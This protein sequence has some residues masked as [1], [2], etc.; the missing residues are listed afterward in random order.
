MLTYHHEMY[1]VI[2]ID[3]CMSNSKLIVKYVQHA[4]RFIK[5]QLNEND[6]HNIVRTEIIFN[7]LHLNTILN[8]RDPIYLLKCQHGHVITSIIRCGINT[9]S[10]P[11]FKNAAV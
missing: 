1:C 4:H 8:N 2:F 7:I 3:N 11:N 5:L 6:S 10:F 9:C